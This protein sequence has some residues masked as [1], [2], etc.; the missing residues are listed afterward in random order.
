MRDFTENDHL[1]KSNYLSSCQNLPQSP[2]VYSRMMVSSM[3]TIIPI[4][5]ELSGSLEG[6]RNLCIEAQ[7]GL[8]E[9]FHS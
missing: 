3:D 6:V 2:G 4:Y 1:R 5:S 7:C 9:W 8:V